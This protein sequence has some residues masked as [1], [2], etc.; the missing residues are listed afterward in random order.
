MALT[1]HGT[2]SDNE[3]ILSRHNSKPLIING[4]M[5][6]FQRGTSVTSVTSNGVKVADRMYFEHGSL[7]TWTIAQ[8]TDVPTGQGFKYSQKYDCTTADAS[9]ASGDYLLPI[10]YHFEGQD[11]QLLKKGTSS[12]EPITVAV[13]LKSNLTGNFILEIW[14]REND[15]QISSALNITSANTWTKFVK[16][17]AGDTTGT[18]SAD[19]SHRFSIGIWGDSGSDFRG[20]TLQTSWGAKTNA[21]R[22]EGN[23]NL[24]NS[25]DNELLVCGL[26]MEIGSF[27]ENSMPPFQHDDIGTSLA[28]CM[29][30]Y[31]RNQGTGS[32]REY[33][34]VGIKRDSYSGSDA[35]VSGIMT[36]KVRKRATPTIG[37]NG[38][39]S[40]VYTHGVSSETNFSSINVQNIGLDHARFHGEL[41]STTANSGGIIARREETDRYYDIDSEL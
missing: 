27:D 16:T 40:F 4:D 11:L 29:R 24:G 13:W 22:A 2:V 15:R 34:S 36:Y 37:Y 35:T 1:L 9:P 19:S 17:F 28:R 20:G 5:N 26:Q 39:T 31:E 8:S 12:A 41:S 21:N 3:V 18:L 6:I 38:A 30:Y 33:F 10:E 14:D 32:N 7:G 23:V 25:T